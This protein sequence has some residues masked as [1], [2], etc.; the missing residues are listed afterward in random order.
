MRKVVV[1]VSCSRC[2]RT[3]TRAFDTEAP[4]AAPAPPPVF[5]GHMVGVPLVV[6][7]DLC[8]PC[9]RTVQTLLEQIGKKVKGVSPDRAVKTE[10]TKP[11]AKKEA[12]APGAP[13]PR[14]TA[15]VAQPSAKAASTRSAS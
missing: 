11:V 4:P 14:A 7:E 1:E 5:T 15:P 12:Q 3:E 13:T 8:A 9:Q 10:E 2:E 6:F